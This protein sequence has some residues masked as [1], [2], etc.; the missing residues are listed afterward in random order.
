LASHTIFL[1]EET[2]QQEDITNYI[3][4]FVNSDPK[5]RKWREQDKK[6]VIEKLSERADGM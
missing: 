4:W 1:Q 5:A 2:G 6:L 3:K